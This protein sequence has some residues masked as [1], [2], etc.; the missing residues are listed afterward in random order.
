MRSFR[1]LIVDD[2]PIVRLGLRTI[3]S[4]SSLSIDIIGEASNGN[5]ALSILESESADIAIIDMKMPGMNGIELMKAMETRNIKLN[6]IVLSAYQD[7]AYVREAFVLG[8]RDYIIK[9]DLDDAHILPVMQNLLDE[10][11]LERGTMI[12]LDSSTQSVGALFQDWLMDRESFT[13]EQLSEMRDY[14]DLKLGLNSFMVMM[15]K[16]D[17]YDQ[18][19]ER[20]SRLTDVMIQ[21][22]AQCVE[23]RKESAEII[24]MANHQLCIIFGFKGAYSLMHFRNAFNTLANLIRHRLSSYAQISISISMSD[25]RQGFDQVKQLYRQA[26]ELLS[27]RFYKGYGKTFYPEQYQQVLTT[28]AAGQKECLERFQALGVKILRDWSQGYPTWEEQWVTWTSIELKACGL[29]SEVIKKRFQDVLWEIGA[30]IHKKELRWS[31]LGPPYHEPFKFLDEAECLDELWQ[32]IHL[33]LKKG[34]EVLHNISFS[35]KIKAIS[36]VRTFIEQHYYEPITLTLISEMTGMSESHFSKLFAKE[37]N[38]NFIDYLTR[39]RINKAIELLTSPMKLYE[40]SEKVGYMNPEHF[41]RMFKKVT[42]LS[43]NQYREQLETK[44]IK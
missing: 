42:G 9:T 5:D 33:I 19:K 25:V 34:F 8:A 38:Q 22:I 12:E 6:V 36:E 44:N 2:E 15:V 31:Q 26:E 41:S 24:R 18:E 23:E 30:T 29:T 21:T 3:L 32:R 17:Q 37:M 4:R 1:L 14:T 40:I 7:Y 35:S 43:P 10:L 39:V 16:I 13:P 28:D 20:N 11:T 27:L